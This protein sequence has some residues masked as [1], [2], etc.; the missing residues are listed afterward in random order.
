MEKIVSKKYKE[1]Y[2]RE[3]L[4]NGLEVVLFEKPNYSKS[5]F[6]IGTPYG[7]CDYQQEDR[8]G[9]VYTYPKGVAHFLEHKMFEKEGKDVLEEFSALGANVNAFTSYT[10]TAY[11]FSTSNN[12]IEPL[13]LLLDFVQELTITEESV[14]KE[15][16]IICQELEMYNQMADSKLISETLKNTFYEHPLKDDIGGTIESVN[17]ITYND[18][19]E[20]YNNNYHPSKTILVGVTG[21]DVNLLLDVI[22]NNQS[23]KRFTTV[24]KME[25]VKY[26]EPYQIKNK[27]YCFEMEITTPKV[28]K[29]YK[30]R[31]IDNLEEANRKEWC[32]KI[33]FDLYF[34]T[35]NPNYQN[36][37]DEEIINDD[38]S[39]EIDLG[40]DY[41]M[42]LFTGETNKSD[43]FFNLV[44][45]TIKSIDNFDEDD[46]NNLK[47]RYF[48]RTIKSLDNFET[49]AI[50]F[51]RSRFN[52]IDYF[53]SLDVVENITKNEV[54]ESLKLIDVNN[55][56]NLKILPKK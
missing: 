22:K 43:E 51:M 17:Q 4:D 18:L 5:F 53:K 2:V 48:G 21:Y 20:C 19:M 6:I 27:E 36:W 23:E 35:I 13:N 34:S 9:K 30:L 25:R 1:S 45:K 37:L 52:G 38:F 28:A 31:G 50:D 47:H 54:I 46:F 24:E 39:F 55:C 12:P 16:G 11:Y 15:K 44:D 32:L 56:L 29:M 40:K 33:A 10:E 7:G 41:G 26:N 49:I 3:V 42:V 8:N 14:E